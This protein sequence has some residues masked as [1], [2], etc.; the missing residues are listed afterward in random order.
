MNWNS[1]KVGWRVRVHSGGRKK[2][3]QSCRVIGSSLS[4]SCCLNV[5]QLLFGVRVALTFRHINTAKLEKQLPNSRH[6][7]IRLLSN[8][9]P[10]KKTG[11]FMCGTCFFTVNC[12]Y[13]ITK[14]LLWVPNMHRSNQQRVINS[15]SSL[16][17]LWWRIL[18]GEGVLKPQISGD[19]YCLL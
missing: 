7:S 17:N 16:M 9:T 12:S 5:K 10:F 15:P 4:L 18:T 6:G 3:L 19:F 1:E 13:V 11:V 2:L 8:Q 14:T